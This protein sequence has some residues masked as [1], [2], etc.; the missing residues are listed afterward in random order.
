MQLSYEATDVGSWSIMCSY[1]P[2][3]KKC[4]L[5]ECQCILYESTSWGHYFLRLLPETGPP[6]YV[7]NR[8]TRGSSRLQGKGNTLISQLF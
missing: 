5:F 4:T 3:E 1:V 2:L 8:A 6:F 7:A